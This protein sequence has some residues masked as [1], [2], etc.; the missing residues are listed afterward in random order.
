MSYNLNITHPLIEN[1]QKYTYYKKTVSIHSEDRDI[2]KY[3]LSSQF[4]FTLP[5]DYLNVQSVKLS[6]WSFPFNMNVFS[7]SNNNVSLTFKIN[8]SYN[9]GE[10]D[11]PDIL[12]NAIFEA[13]YNYYNDGNYFSITIETGN[14]KYL[15]MAT[16]LQNKMNH[17]VTV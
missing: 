16:E 13:L 4:E 15:Q 3:P 12:Q 2:L 8:K 17:V 6:S 14:Y 10:F 11:V 7:A 1:A 9:P 5:Q